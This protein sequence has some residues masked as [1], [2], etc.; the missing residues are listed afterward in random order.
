VTVR[1]SLARLGVPGT[2]TDCPLQLR[3]QPD[4]RFGDR[5][6]GTGPPR[7]GCSKPSRS[8]ND[9]HLATTIARRRAAAQSRRRSRRRGLPVHHVSSQPS[10]GDCLA[11]CRP[12][13]SSGAARPARSRRPPAAAPQLG[14]CDIA[15]G[16]AGERAQDHRAHQ[17]PAAT[18]LRDRRQRG[19][20]RGGDRARELVRRRRHPPPRRHRQERALRRHDGDDRRPVRRPRGER[21]ATAEVDGRLDEAYDGS[22]SDCNKGEYKDIE[23]ESIPEPIRGRLADTLRGMRAN[24]HSS[25]SDAGGRVLA[26]LTEVNDVILGGENGEHP[27]I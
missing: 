17:G 4:D 20:A 7:R 8:R 21:G 11:E 23:G 14:R 24:L 10:A 22:A 15:H 13:T 25:I 2:G 27:F 19:H 16:H 1:T 12:T 6:V 5:L 26:D 3:R 9:A 18:G